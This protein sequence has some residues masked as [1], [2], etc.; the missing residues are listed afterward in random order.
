MKRKSL[1][2]EG[3][4]EL[5]GKS[6]LGE[7][8]SMH[9]VVGVEICQCWHSEKG[10]FLKQLSFQ[11][12]CIPLRHRAPGFAYLHPEVLKEKQIGRLFPSFVTQ[13]CGTLGVEEPLKSFPFFP[14][15]PP[16]YPLAS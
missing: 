13:P 11:H 6:S 8:A 14:F 15:P 16:L 2:E 3:T 4:S 12:T 1:T 9:S 7:A 5:H 10:L